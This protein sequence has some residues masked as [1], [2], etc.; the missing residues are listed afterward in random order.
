MH[1]IPNIDGEGHTHAICNCCGCGCFALR[2]GTMFQNV[3]MVR[4]NYVASV[5][6]KMCCMRRVCEKLPH[7]CIALRSKS[8]FAETGG[9]KNRM[10][11]NPS[12]YGLVR[13]R[14]NGIWNIA[15]TAKNVVETGTAPC[16][17]KCPAHIS[18]QGYIRLASQGKYKE[19]LELIKRDNRSPRCAAV[20]ARTVAKA[21]V[22]EPVLMSQ[23]PLTR[24][25]N[26]LPIRN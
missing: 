7:E 12:R 1:Q 11:R 26:S 13:C 10:G 21:N 15:P 20:Y 2:S 19:A 24:L 6:R 25:K 3:D 9:R 4:S 8:M 22:P 23:S 14:K 17:T 18:V 16:K 5:E